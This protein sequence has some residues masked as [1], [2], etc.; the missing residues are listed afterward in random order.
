MSRNHWD[1]IL[2]CGFW[3]VL[4]LAHLCKHMGMFPSGVHALTHPQ[5]TAA[6]SKNNKKKKYIDSSDL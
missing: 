2:T 1:C 5:A 4:Q 3:R 6:L